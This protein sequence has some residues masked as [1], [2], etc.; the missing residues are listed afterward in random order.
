[1]HEFVSFHCGI[2]ASGGTSVSALSSATLYGKGIFTTIAIHDSEAFLWEKH[3]RRLVSN[4]ETAKIDIAEF[5][6][7]DVKQALA[8]IIRKNN[9]IDGRARITFFDESPSDIWPFETTRKVGLL[10][11][12]TEPR[13]VANNF[14]LTVSPY[15]VNSL[16]P[17]AGLKSCNYLDKLLTL[18]EARSRGFNEA[19]QV[20]ERGE[21]TSA[22]MANIF[23]LKGGV[24]YTPSLVTGCLAGTTR[25]FVLENLECR[26]TKGS[27]DE[28]NEADAIFLT[29]AGLGVAQVAELGSRQLKPIDHPILNLLPKRF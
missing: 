13:P 12:T 6:E 16:S 22:S 1:M 25:E 17:L 9:C 19:I 21:V 15:S 29:S 14:R 24:L 7:S 20:N 26:E 18:D 10:I 23:W 2:I 11:T 5:S 4:A 27:I 3:W 8:E 28:L